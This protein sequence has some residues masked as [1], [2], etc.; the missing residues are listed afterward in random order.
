MKIVTW[1]VNGIRAAERNG[2]LTWV[3]QEQPDVLCLQEIKAEPGQLSEDLTAPAGY[4]TIWHPA[5]AKKGYSGTA[6]WTKVAPQSVEIGI[7]NPEIDG[8]GRVIVVHF[9]DFTLFNIYFPNGSRDLSRVPFKLAFYELLLERFDAL[10]AA[11][12]KLVVCGDYNTCHERIDLANPTANSKATGFLPEEREW[13]TKYLAHGF[14]D[15]YRDRNPEQ[16][17][18]YSWWSYRPGV[19]EKNIGWR[20]D[21]FLVSTGLVPAVSDVVHRP[22]VL[23]SDHCPVVLELAA[24]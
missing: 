17:G 3:A 10:H 6:V 7:G 24:S 23:G 20:L 11:G 15:V 18:A 12:R 4:Q 22:E 21:Y 2:L 13:I 8:E 14:Q 16:K 5:T 1:N 9:A 19:R